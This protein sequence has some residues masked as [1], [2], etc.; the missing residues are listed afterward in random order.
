[1]STAGFIGRSPSD[2]LK[3]VL[4]VVLSPTHASKRTPPERCEL[5]RYL[6]ETGESIAETFATEVAKSAKKDRSAVKSRVGV[7]GILV[8]SSSNE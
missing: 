8:I 5:V 2:R 7:S 4:P 6:R 3:L 1:M